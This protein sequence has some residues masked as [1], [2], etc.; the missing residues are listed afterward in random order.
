MSQCRPLL[1]PPPPLSALLPLTSQ[2][3]RA[4]S[5]SFVVLPPPVR[6][7]WRWWQRRQLGSLMPGPSLLPLS[8]R[9][10]SQALTPLDNAT[11]LRKQMDCIIRVEAI[12][13]EGVGGDT[14]LCLPP[15]LTT[16]RCINQPQ[17]QGIQKSVAGGGGNG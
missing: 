12:L 5:S 10:Q 7:W 2:Q 15:K 11:V 13:G 17:Q 16:K 4:P 1:H 14:C 8:G 3:R 6:Q 9:V